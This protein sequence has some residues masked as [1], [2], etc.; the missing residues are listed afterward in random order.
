[1]ELALTLILRVVCGIIAA[2][3]ASSKGRNVAGWFFGGFFIG[4]IGIIIV[5]CLPNLRQQRERMRQM[6]SSRRRMA[7]QLRQERMKGEAFRG[8]T[9]GRL[10]AHD[11]AL[12]M[13]TRSVAGAVLGQG[14]T[15]AQLPAR[16]VGPPSPLEQLQYAAGGQP[17][18]VHA[19]A[20]AEQAGGGWHYEL[21]GQSRG[22]VS[23]LTIKELLQTGVIGGANLLWVE[24]MADWKRADQVAL[25]RSVVG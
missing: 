22:P 9:V 21:N 4:L 23:A 7:E 5:A 12:G 18:P 14:E 17:T 6:E 13:D 2:A 8:Y 20:E 16:Q 15:P 24:G 1:M 3:I 19:A 10:D 25:F 11:Q